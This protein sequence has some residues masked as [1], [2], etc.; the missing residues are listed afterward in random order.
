MA[1]SYRSDIVTYAS[2]HPAPAGYIEALERANRAGAITWPEL[3]ELQRRATT[4]W[5]LVHNQ[6]A[7]IYDE[8]DTPRCLRCLEEPPC[9]N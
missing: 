6:P 4:L 3:Q 9:L 2:K 5:C 1:H 8:H 7:L